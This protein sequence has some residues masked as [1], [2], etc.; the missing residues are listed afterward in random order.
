MNDIAYSVKIDSTIIANMS[1]IWLEENVG[2][3]DIDWSIVHLP[4][5]DLTSLIV[6]S[7]IKFK[8]KEDAAR[9]TLT[10]L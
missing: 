9:F 10:W 1:F 5:N 6:E 2:V 3:R 4:S 8:N 7:Y